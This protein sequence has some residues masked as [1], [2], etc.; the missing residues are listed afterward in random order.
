MDENR[1]NLGLGGTENVRFVGYF[2]Y[3]K[4]VAILKISIEL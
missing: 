3:F 4:G 2:V 1:E